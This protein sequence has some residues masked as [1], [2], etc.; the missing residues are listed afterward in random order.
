MGGDPIDDYFN[1]EFVHE[2][3]FFEDK[4]GGNLGF[5]GDS[6][7]RA[8]D[9]ANLSKYYGCFC[10]T[11]EMVKTNHAACLDKRPTP[12]YQAGI[13]A[14]AGNFPSLCSW[15]GV[16]DANFLPIRISTSR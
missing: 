11:P 5:F 3:L 4:Q 12:D 1:T 16:D 10:P 9:P 13:T 7:V 15:R 8:D 6:N 2:Q 14:I